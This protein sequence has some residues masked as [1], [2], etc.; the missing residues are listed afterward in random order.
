MHR[1]IDPLLDILRKKPAAA[2]CMDLEDVVYIS[3]ICSHSCCCDLHRTPEYEQM[4]GEKLLDGIGR[5]AFHNF[6]QPVLMSVG[7][8]ATG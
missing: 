8:V 4:Q 3:S 5:I 7:G 6:L 2:L 1:G